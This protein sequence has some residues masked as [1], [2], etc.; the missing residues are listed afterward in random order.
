MRTNRFDLALL[1]ASFQGTAAAG[2]PSSNALDVSYTFVDFVSDFEKPY[3]PGT[4]EW[5]YREDIFNDNLSQILSHN[6]L[7]YASNEND[8]SS[9]GTTYTKGVNKFTDKLASE[10]YKGFDKRQHPA[11][12]F[13]PISS[14]TRKLSVSQLLLPY[15]FRYIWIDNFIMLT[16][17]IS[18][19]FDVCKNK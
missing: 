7:F 9:K 4:E 5:K 12:G 19:H 8:S 11:Y 14:T 18:N 2:P 10:I 3:E 1:L 6:A 16:L 15:S 13:S 17:Y